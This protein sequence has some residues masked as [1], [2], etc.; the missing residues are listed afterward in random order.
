MNEQE[1]KA[2]V[3]Q[4]NELPKEEQE[5]VARATVCAISDAIADTIEQI[6]EATNNF[7]VPAGV[8]YAA[9]S[10]HGCTLELFTLMIDKLVDSG[11]LERKGNLLFAK[12]APVNL[13]N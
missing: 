8:L 5:A 2:K 6:N 9:L 12:K 4:L 7:G 13:N 10:S 3:K 11:R 1:L